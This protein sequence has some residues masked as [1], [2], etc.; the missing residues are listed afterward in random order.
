MDE[1]LQEIG[2]VSDIEEPWCPELERDPAAS[3]TLL[4]AYDAVDALTRRVE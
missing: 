4:A 3:G 2:G 1:R